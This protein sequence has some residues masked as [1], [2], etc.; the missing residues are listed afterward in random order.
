MPRLCKLKI[1]GF[2]DWEDTSITD[3]LRYA[4]RLKTNTTV[5][6]LTF[7]QKRFLWRLL[8][9]YPLPRQ[10][11]KSDERKD[12][13]LAIL[14]LESA[15]SAKKKRKKERRTHLAAVQLHFEWLW[16][17][18]RRRLDLEPVLA[19]LH[20]LLA[21]LE[22]AVEGQ[23]LH[24]AEG[25]KGRKRQWREWHR[26]W[27][28]GNSLQLSSRLFVI[29]SSWGTKRETHSAIHWTYRG[30]PPVARRPIIYSR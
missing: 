7:T 9:S 21:L 29:R 16:L 18:R 8:P 28:N 11:T 15:R 3:L 19:V 12:N 27:S 10:E 22:Q 6:F 1:L 14:T 23:H 2:W 26:T 30:A 24:K 5:F 25:E 13:W 20:R 17:G 4:S